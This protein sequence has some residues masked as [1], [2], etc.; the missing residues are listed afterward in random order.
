MA[1]AFLCLMALKNSAEVNVLLLVVQ[2]PKITSNLTQV[3]W[4]ESLYTSLLAAVSKVCQL[5]AG[6]NLAFSHAVLSSYL[7]FSLFLP[8]LP[9]VPQVFPHF[10]RV[11]EVLA[12]ALLP[13]AISPE[14]MC[15]LGGGGPVQCDMRLDPPTATANCG[16]KV[17]HFASKISIST[18]KG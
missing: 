4:G 16:V 14:T 13:S 6:V 17:H 15:S 5:Q 8:I 1:T 18:R 10:R 3:W 12:D 2:S 11:Q 7:Y 9:P